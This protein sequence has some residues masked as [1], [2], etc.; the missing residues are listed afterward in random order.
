MADIL[1]SWDVAGTRADWV[2]VEGGLAAGNPIISQILISVFSDRL[3]AT[4]DEIPGGTGNPRGWWGDAGEDRPIGSRMW[5]LRRAKQT[6]ETLQRAFDYLAEA[7]QWMIDDKVVTK[8]EIA[9]KWVRQ[10]F[11][12]AV[13]VAHLPGGAAP[14]SVST[15]WSL[16]GGV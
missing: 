14:V 11:L 13:I 6:Q 7:L 12:G 10:S 1:V 8:F 15:D 16:A 5:L 2:L 3:A 9:V 4:D